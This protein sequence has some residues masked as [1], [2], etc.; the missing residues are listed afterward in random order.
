[1]R[2]PVLAIAIV[3]V[4]AVPCT[5]LGEKKKYIE[6]QQPSFGA[7]NGPTST[8]AKGS[9]GKV[10]KTPFTITRYVDK[11]SPVFFM[12]PVGGSTGPAKPTLP[13]TGR[14]Q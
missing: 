1:M 13:T 3:F 4:L 9:T 8:S 7:S 2:N 11:A 10:T 12:K 6:V 5:A 14:R